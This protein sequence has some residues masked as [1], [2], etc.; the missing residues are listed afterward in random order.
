MFHN[1]DGIKMVGTIEQTRGIQDLFEKKLDELKRKDYRGYRNFCSELFEWGAAV[2]SKL[3]GNLG[4]LVKR[5][6]NFIAEDVK[7]NP[8]ELLNSMFDNYIQGDDY[9]FVSLFY[10]IPNNYALKRG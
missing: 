7:A 10:H 2:S 1:Q 6:I 9:T 3:N 5:Q 4:D 8:Q